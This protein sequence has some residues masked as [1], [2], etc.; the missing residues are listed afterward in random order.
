MPRLT[1]RL[2]SLLFMLLPCLQACAY[3][4]KVQLAEVEGGVSHGRKVSVKVSETTLDFREAGQIAQGVGKYSGSRSI[5]ELGKIAEMYATFFQWGPKTGAPVFNELYA[6]KIPEA[7]AA[8]CK[9]GRLANIISVREARE[10]PVIKGEI[11]RVDAVCI[12]RGRA[13]K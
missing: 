5:G 7:L 12:S 1:K 4:H 13:E 11:V 3:L 10:Y 9:G 8:R 6:R 2:G